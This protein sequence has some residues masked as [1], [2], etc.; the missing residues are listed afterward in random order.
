MIYLD[1]NFFVYA[2]LDTTTK[3][4]TAS[5][6][7]ESIVKGKVEAATSA[8][9][10]GELMRVLVKN[11]RQ[12]LVRRAIED[13]YATP[14]LRVSEVGSGI[15]IIAL[16]FLYEYGLKPRDAF[17]AAIMRSLGLR[18]IVSDDPDFDKIK[19]IRRISLR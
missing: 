12:E 1:A 3:G 6:I 8:L 7:Q 2:L 14:N 10:L 5:S 4:Q 11:R 16:D 15:P 19:W 13:I 18:E 17:H 9:A